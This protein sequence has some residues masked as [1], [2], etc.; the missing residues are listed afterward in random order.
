MPIASATLCVDIGNS[1][2]RC[3]VVPIESP[4][5]AE[6]PSR[7][8]FARPWIGEPLRIDWPPQDINGTLPCDD[9]TQSQCVQHL[10]TQLRG[11]LD[12]FASDE[13]PEAVCRPSRW[14]VSSVQRTTENALRQCANELGVTDYILLDH[15]AIGLNVQ[16]DYPERVGVDRLLA[17]RAAMSTTQARPLIV[18]QAG[19]AITVDWIEGPDAFCGGAIM[20]GVPMM[21]R[22]LGRGAD[23]LPEITAAD[24]LELP[25][26]PGKNTEA[27]MTLGASSAVVGGV[28][29]LVQRYRARC[30]QPVTIVLSGGDGPRLAPHLTEP[31]IT[32]DHLVLRGLAE[33]ARSQDAPS[34]NRMNQHR[35]SNDPFDTI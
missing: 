6:Q 31:L 13:V 9:A 15:Q 20:P 14:L 30:H 29:H 5:S 26:I 16:V 34:K 32:L 19:S 28:Q 11:W 2:L 3:I 1:G 12:S 23:L 21:V 25:P 35:K 24:L 27:A 18:I 22:L 10:T 4:S 8:T 17:A 33:M 7:P